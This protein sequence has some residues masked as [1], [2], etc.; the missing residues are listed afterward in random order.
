MKIGIMADTHDHCDNIRKAVSFFNKQNVEQVIHAGDV[1]AP[2]TYEEFK[3]LKAPIVMIFGNNDGEK[4]GL[5]KKFK[6]IYL[7]PYECEFD[8]KRFV[9]LH[10]PNSLNSI[11]AGRLFCYIIYGHIHKVDVRKGDVTVINPGEVC[12]W[13]SVK[14]TIVVLDTKTN[15]VDVYEL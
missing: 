6:T 5:Q 2:F 14:S 7:P 12:G 3:F 13:V 4:I 15:E 8:G 11:I 10:E 1:V 9:I